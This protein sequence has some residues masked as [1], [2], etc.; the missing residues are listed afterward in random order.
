MVE[1]DE[2]FGVKKGGELNIKE[3]VMMHIK[4]ISDLSCKELTPSYWT[5]RPVAVGE[6]I[7]VVETYHEDKR[8]AYI[9]AVDFLLDVLIPHSDKIFKQQLEEIEKEEERQHKES[10]KKG[11]SEEN[12]IW[13]KLRLRKTLFRQLMITIERI[14]FFKTFVYTEGLEDDFVEGEAE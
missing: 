5:K 6:G 12:W 2:W 13:K 1:S 4:K 3:V 9:N 8:L 7:A 11:E 10:R 14:G